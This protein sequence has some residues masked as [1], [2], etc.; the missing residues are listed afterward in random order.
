MIGCGLLG[1]FADVYS[2]ALFS[3]SNAI[4]IGAAITGPLLDATHKYNV[5]LRGGMGT[6]CSRLNRICSLTR[7][8]CRLCLLRCGCYR[9]RVVLASRSTDCCGIAVAGCTFLALEPCHFPPAVFICRVH[10]LVYL[11]SPFYLCYPLPSSVLSSM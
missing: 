7:V 10:S 5:M 8:R 3:H 4:Y 9:L 6:C 2:G 11:D 1:L